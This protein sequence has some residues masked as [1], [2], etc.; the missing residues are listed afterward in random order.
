MDCAWVVGSRKDCKIAFGLG[1]LGYDIAFFERLGPGRLPGSIYSGTTV[2]ALQ[3][4]FE[5]A[6]GLE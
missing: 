4:D 6:R 1:R 3:L 2:L 5:I